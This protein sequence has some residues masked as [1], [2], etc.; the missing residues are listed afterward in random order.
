[1][2]MLKTLS[3][4]NIMGSAAAE[5]ETHVKSKGYCEMYRNVMPSHSLPFR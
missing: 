2:E 1:M 5:E 3:S 4:L